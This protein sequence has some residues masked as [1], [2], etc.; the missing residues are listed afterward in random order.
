MIHP[1]SAHPLIRV[2]AGGRV[3]DPASGFD[4]V[5]DV[6]IADGTI[7]RIESK[8]GADLNDPAVIDAR[9]LIVTPGFVDLHVHLREPGREDEETVESGSAAGVRGGFTT[10]CCMPNTDPAIADQGMV[11]FVLDRALSAPGRVHPIG[12]ITR[13]RE[14][15]VL[16]EIA[17]MVAAGAI[18]FSDDGSPVENSGLLRR[19]M[20]YSRMFDVPIVSHCETL[21]LALN[22]VMHEGL[23]STILGLRGIPAISEDICVARDIALARS[24]GARL[25]IAHVSTAGAV[26]IIRTAKAEGVRVTAEVTP[27]HLILTDDIIARDFDP[28]FKVNPPLRTAE[29][30]KAVREGLIDGTIDCIATDHAPHAWQEKDGEFDLAPF[31]MIG[32]ETALGVV[33]KALIETGLMD[34]PALVDCLTRRA[35][36]AFSLPVGRLTAGCEA[37]LVCFDPKAQWTVTDDSF[38]SKS[39]NSPYLGWTLNGVVRATLV[40]G[41]LVYRD[42]GSGH[43]AKVKHNRTET[44]TANA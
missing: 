43:A 13:E 25:H 2:V 41:R 36:G 17:E 1:V 22:G 7:E 16:A 27:H 15:E 4:A 21:S 10:L 18:A 8:S 6:W 20:E 24:T 44:Q 26:E 9:G 28:L 33:Q 32:L 5:A 11:R 40:A 42:A 12:A 23:V 35:A 37:D 29:D 3:I 31:G 39:K 34:W 38:V 19:A 14:G 30:V